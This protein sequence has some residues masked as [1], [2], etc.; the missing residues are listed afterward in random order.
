[1]IEYQVLGGP[2]VAT[3]ARSAGISERSMRRAFE[4]RLRAIVWGAAL[5]WCAMVWTAVY[6]AA[7]GPL[8]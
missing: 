1:M 5:L 4:R 7:G 3:G 2:R 6:V 8:P